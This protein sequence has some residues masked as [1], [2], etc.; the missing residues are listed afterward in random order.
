MIYFY[1]LL[2]KQPSF[3]DRR[4]VLLETAKKSNAKDWNNCPYENRVSAITPGSKRFL[5]GKNE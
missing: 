4:I 5:S 3:K 2:G 1:W